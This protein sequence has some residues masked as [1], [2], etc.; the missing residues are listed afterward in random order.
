M[1][2]LLGSIVRDGDN[3]RCCSGAIIPRE[4]EIHP[5]PAIFIYSSWTSLR[6]NEDDSG[7]GE[8]AERDKKTHLSELGHQC[9]Q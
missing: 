5:R 4:A 9:R 2:R 3:C 6:Q 7:R 1:E 8:T